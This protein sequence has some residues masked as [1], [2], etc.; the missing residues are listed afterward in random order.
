MADISNKVE[1]YETNPASWIFKIQ[2]FSNKFTNFSFVAF[3][4]LKNITDN[5]SNL[6][7]KFIGHICMPDYQPI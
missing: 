5:T 2:L 7:F 6:E 1:S 4:F 3:F